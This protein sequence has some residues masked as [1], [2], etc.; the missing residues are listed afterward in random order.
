VL[1]WVLSGRPSTTTFIAGRQARRNPMS[2]PLCSHCKDPIAELRA[3]AMKAK[4]PRQS[5]TVIT[6]YCPSCSSVLS[7]EIQPDVLKQ[8]LKR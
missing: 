4:A 5:W 1:G 7:V 6:Y 2:Q 8:F 3:V